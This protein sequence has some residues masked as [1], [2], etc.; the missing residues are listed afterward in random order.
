MTPAEKR[1]A[2]LDA[3]EEYQ[4]YAE[5]HATTIANDAATMLKASGYSAW[6]FPE[7]SKYIQLRDAANRLMKEIES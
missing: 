1:K 5:L 4:K 2:A 3:I 7:L 6:I